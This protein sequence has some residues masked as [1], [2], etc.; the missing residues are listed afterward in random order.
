MNLR[1][2]KRL[3]GLLVGAAARGD[4]PRVAALLR[5]G[6]PAAAADSEGTTALYAAAVAG[7]ERAVRDLLAGGADPDAQSGGP[8]DGTPLCGAAAWGHAA[9]VAAL[10]AGGADPALRED[11][12]EGPTPLEWAL[13]GGHAETARLLRAAGPSG[14]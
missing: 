4:A 9:A 5:S 8:T 11:D 12:G 6:A 10:L 13:R 14:G 2:R 3:S 7:A 1:E